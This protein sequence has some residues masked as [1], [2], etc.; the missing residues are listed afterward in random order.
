[1]EILILGCSSVFLRR[2]LPALNSCEKIAK[3]NIASKSHSKLFLKETVGKKFGNY[4]DNYSSAIDSCSDMVYISLA[5]HLHF[6][7]AKKSLEQG[8]HVI[9][10]KPATL[11]LDDT[12]YLVNLSLKNSLCL[13]ESTVWPFH[14]CINAVKNN[15]IKN[16]GN[17]ISINA[18]F[19][20]PDFEKTNY[21]NFHEYGGGA[22]NDLSA[23]AVSIG[24]VFL[25]EKPRLISGKIISF[26]KSKGIDTVFSVK[27][28]FSNNQIFKGFYG[29]GLKYA[30]K[31]KIYGADFEYQLN[32]LFSP[33][34]DL[35]LQLEMKVGG[36]SK[37]KSF[38]GDV[39]ANFF[40]KVIE[41]LDNS[42]KFDWCETLYED[43]KITSKLKSSVLLEKFN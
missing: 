43:A 33:P 1:M 18:K 29:F 12:K 27:M 9:V 4:F 22:F 23:Y 17:P 16:K 32:R 10:E 36:Q 14:P 41:S 25:N 21:R 15:I 6:I 28:E 31:L 30:N 26:D 37:N 38:K 2:V 42:R 20:V 34:A 19:T 24:R 8:L 11:N 13:A 5:N 35:D 7:W 3:I 40:T 39:Y